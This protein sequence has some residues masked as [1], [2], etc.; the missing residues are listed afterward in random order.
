LGL[1][2][3]Q[4]E[5]GRSALRRK[6]GRNLW[7]ESYSWQEQ[8]RG[9]KIEQRPR[10]MPRWKWFSFR[11]AAKLHRW[12]RVA[13]LINSARKGAPFVVNLRIQWISLIRNRQRIPPTIQLLGTVDDIVEQEDNVD[14]QSGAEF[15]YKDVLTRGMRT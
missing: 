1:L 4:D 2:Q 3:N 11:L 5:P 13:K 7:S 10:H 12:F 9:W 6:R 15:I 14:V 8:N